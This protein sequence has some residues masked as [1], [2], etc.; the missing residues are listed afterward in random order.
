MDLLM[1]Y[2]LINGCLDMYRYNWS[3][4]K[5][6]L[7]TRQVAKGFSPLKTLTYHLGTIIALFDTI[8]SDVLLS[9]AAFF[10]LNR[11]EVL[12]E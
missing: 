8:L 11:S 1:N 10:V 3:W 2:N 9:R 5:I 12:A 6:T 7:Y 4:L